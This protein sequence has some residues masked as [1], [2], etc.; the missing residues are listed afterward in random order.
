MASDSI[1]LTRAN[2]HRAHGG[3]CARAAYAQC[4]R[5]KH[6]VSRSRGSVE[7]LADKFRLGTFT[8]LPTW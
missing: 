4:W 2:A 7:Q 1:K 5:G 3:R 8:V 6:D